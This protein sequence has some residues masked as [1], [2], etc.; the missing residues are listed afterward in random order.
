MVWHSEQ[1]TEVKIAL[2]CATVAGFGWDV[3]VAGGASVGLGV[4]VGTALAVADGKPVAVAG[5]LVGVAGCAGG[6][7]RWSDTVAIAYV[8]AWTTAGTGAV[9]VAA[10]EPTAVDER[11]PQLT[12]AMAIVAVRMTHH[13]LTYR[14]RLYFAPIA[15]FPRPAR[16]PNGQHQRQHALGALSCPDHR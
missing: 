6:V 8:A 14:P 1:P 16:T 12:R 13:S 5:N 11:P 10:T 15:P 9:G 4:A 3:A 2:P 7:A